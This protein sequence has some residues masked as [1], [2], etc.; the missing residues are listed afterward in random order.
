MDRDTLV[1]APKVRPALSGQGH[2]NIDHQ[3]LDVLACLQPDGVARAR[4]LEN[5][6]DLLPGR[7]P[8]D[9]RDPTAGD[10]GCQN[11]NKKEGREPVAARV[12]G[13]GTSEDDLSYPAN[14]VSSESTMLLVRTPATPVLTS[15]C[16]TF[17]MSR[18]RSLSAT[19]SAVRPLQSS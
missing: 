6:S 17:S 19:P 10:D 8:V 14:L 3:V 18:K 4:P 13:S 9:L 11:D 16:Q 15:I 2:G 5:R 12:T 7:D 1:A